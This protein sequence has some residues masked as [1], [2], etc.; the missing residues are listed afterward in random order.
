M[1]GTVRLVTDS[2]SVSRT[3]LPGDTYGN[4]VHKHTFTCTKRGESACRFNIPYWTMHETNVLLPMAKDNGRHATLHKKAKKLKKLLEE[5]SYDTI[6][7]FMVDNKLTTDNYLNV[8]HAS[9]KRPML[10]F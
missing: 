8:I 1:N 4:Q 2:C 9:I 5:K 10:V 6:D 3:D 7:E